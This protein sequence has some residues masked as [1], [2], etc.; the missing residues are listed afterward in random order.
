MPEG[1]VLEEAMALIHKGDPTRFISSPLLEKSL[2]G[3]IRRRQEAAKSGIA[4]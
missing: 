2:M 1:F 4:Y 3:K